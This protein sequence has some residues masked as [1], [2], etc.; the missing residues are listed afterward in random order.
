LIT[1]KTSPSQ[2]VVGGSRQVGS[3][4]QP[5]VAVGVRQRQAMTKVN[6]EKSFHFTFVPKIEKL[7]ILTSNFYFKYIF[8]IEIHSRNRKI[9]LHYQTDF[10]SKPVRET[11]K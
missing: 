1:T 4:G 9:K 3:G 6:D 10:R 2:V 7:K 8:G 11:E 5:A